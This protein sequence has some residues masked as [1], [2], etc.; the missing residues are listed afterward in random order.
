MLINAQASS[1]LS[2][3][4]ASFRALQKQTQLDF[5]IQ[6]SNPKRN[7]YLVKKITEKIKDTV[8]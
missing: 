2:R 7:K 4:I 3:G 6:Y 1:S 8:P 5:Y